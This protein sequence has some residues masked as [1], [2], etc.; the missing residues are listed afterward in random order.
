MRILFI[1]F[2]FCTNFLHAQDHFLKLFS[3][4]AGIISQ[5]MV[6]AVPNGGTIHLSH[7]NTNRI[8]IRR[9]NKCGNQIWAKQIEHTDGFTYLVDIRKDTNDNFI[10]AGY[11]GEASTGGR[12]FIMSIDLD[13]SVNYMKS[14]NAP[15][16]V[17]TITYSFLRNKD[18][19][20]YLYF[21]YDTGSANPGQISVAKIDLDGKLI[22]FKSFTNM[23][24]WGRAMATDDGGLLFRAGSAFAKM[25]S[26]GTIAWSKRYQ[27]LGYVD[28]PVQVEGGYILFKY[29]SGASN[30]TNNLIKL[31]NFGEIVWVTNDFQ[32]FLPT[33]GI[34]RENGNAL[35]VGASLGVALVELDTSTGTIVRF[36]Q[37]N[38]LATFAS[39]GSDLYEDEEQNILISGTD[40]ANRNVTSMYVRVDSALNIS[41]CNSTNLQLSNVKTPTVIARPNSVTT[42]NQSNQ[43]L[44]IIDEI[45][46][47]SNITTVNVTTICSFQEDRGDLE[48]GKDTILC[49]EEI[50]AI[51]NS[52]STFDDYLWSTGAK[53]KQIVI[54]SAGSYSI[55][56]IAACDTLRDTIKIDYYPNVDLFIGE[57]SSICLGDSL[58]LKS[59]FLL[60]NYLWSTGEST[61]EI[62]VKNAGIY[63]LETTTVCGNVR[64]SI[65]ITVLPLSGRLDLGKDTSIC[66]GA[67]INLGDSLSDFDHFSWS[68]G[69]NTQF[70]TVKDSGLY[71]VEATTVCDTLKDSIRVLLNPELNVSFGMDKRVAK[72]FEDIQLIRNERNGVAVEWSFGDGGKAMG[73]TAVYQYQ[74]A[75]NYIIQLIVTSAEGCQFISEQQIVIQPSDYS[76]PN[77]F[78]PN[79]DGINDEFKPLGKDIKS[80]R[81]RIYDRWGKEVFSKR[82]T[83][84]DG[85]SKD[86]RRM[87]EGVY[88]YV[89]T[90]KWNHGGSINLEGNITL[91]K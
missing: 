52:N 16:N 17:Q 51:G 9:I 38:P 22:W 83:A 25:N 89:I 24:N 65:V 3:N 31:D 67:E 18:G 86:G 56:A 69:E 20:F 60:S 53:T 77:V 23:A 58:V 73:D 75:G 62:T 34:L 2:F 30:R 55:R 32:N 78:S 13:G 90:L 5:S 35:F 46:I 50:L 79:N 49:P 81:L 19:D 41:N 59:T 7:I 70:I 28:Y 27:N 91:L 80:Y 71:I 61:P 26:D 63:W 29:P 40:H 36:K 43:L 87:K 48:L 64:D 88:F 54:S 1:L 11:I 21:N 76:I 4:P 72:T 44:T 66:L 6:A 42:R 39:R 15:T 84:W 10:F 82:E 37:I 8:L 74:V 14:I 85:R 45:Y 33:R 12:P 47:D 57:D 68:T